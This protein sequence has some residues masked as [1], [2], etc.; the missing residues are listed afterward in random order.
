MQRHLL[1]ITILLVSFSSCHEI[2]I[3]KEVK[4]TLLLDSIIEGQKTLL[5][6]IDT[7]Q[8]QYCIRTSQ[9][10][11]VQ[12]NSLSEFHKSWFHYEKKAYLNIYKNLSNYKQQMD[13]IAQEL[14]FSMHQI[15]SLR[16]DLVHRH[17][18]KSKFFNYFLE[19][20]KALNE[21][22]QF[23]EQLNVRYNNN[24]ANFDSLEQK[25]KGIIIQIDALQGSNE[26]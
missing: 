7:L 19:E 15:Q 22:N 14:S 8:I 18:N 9:K 11:V 24:L 23:N 26:N 10:R 2:N 13:S 20:Q 12:I 6:E 5:Q 1:F 4:Y 25:L 17:L 16:K 3:N 21:L